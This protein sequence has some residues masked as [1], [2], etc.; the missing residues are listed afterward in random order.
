[1]VKKTNQMP[2]IF[3][4]DQ[5]PQSGKPTDWY[6]CSMHTSL[7]IG[8]KTNTNGVLKI[9]FSPD[10]GNIDSEITYTV[11]SDQREPH[12]IRVLNVWFRVVFTYSVSPTVFRCNV[13]SGDYSLL[14]TPINVTVQQD[15]DSIIARTISEELSI[16]NNKLD[17]YAIVNKF[18]RNG[19]IDTGSVPED[20]WNGGSTYTGFPTGSPEEFQVFSSDVGDTGVVTFTYLPSSTS[21]EYLTGTATLNGT[22]PVN[23]GVTGYRMHTASYA[24]G[25]ATAFNLGTITIRH[26]TTTTNIFC[27]MPI[28]TSQTYVAAYTVPYGYTGYVKRLFCRVFNQVTGSVEGGLWVRSFGGSPRIRRPF[29]VSNTDAFEEYPFGGVSIPQQSDISI[30]IVSASTTNLEVIGGFDIMLIKN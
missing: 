9:Q 18:G 25:S 29:S 15:A 14:T 4:T 20:I 2:R 16:I 30:R 10:K 28:G 17:G 22:T 24:S 23:T 1:M 12:I 11:G 13:I 8:L 26:R 21:T 7:G 5:I 6:D 19:D 27:A 3:Y